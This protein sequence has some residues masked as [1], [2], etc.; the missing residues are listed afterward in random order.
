MPSK[1]A[2]RARAS[3]RR[4]AR[5]ARRSRPRTTS[6]R[7]A[8]PVRAAT[9]LNR[10]KPVPARLPKSSARPVV[11]AK[12][13]TKRELNEFRRILEAERDRLSQELEAIE[14]HLPEVEQVSMDASGGY[15]E[16]LADVASDTFEREKGFAIENSVQD[17]LTQVEEALGR[18]EEGT[19]GICEVCGQPIHP[20]RL[21]ALPYARLCI[22]CKAREEQ[23]IPQ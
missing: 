3:K 23:A 17:L 18:L 13:L 11:N 5:P 19:Y 6:T 1:A 22:N 7:T 14:E 16:D 10:G 8:R 9:R 4:V 12:P 21:R 15:D 2:G 20:D